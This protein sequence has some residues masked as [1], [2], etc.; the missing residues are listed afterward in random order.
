VGG[1]HSRALRRWADHEYLQRRLLD[2]LHYS[3]PSL[4]NHSHL[5]HHA[6]ADYWPKEFASH[7]TFA[8]H[9][10]FESAHWLVSG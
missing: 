3:E 7:S 8:L 2:I 4:V 1:C 10:T 5:R 9:H 6:I